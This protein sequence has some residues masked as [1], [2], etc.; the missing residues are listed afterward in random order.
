MSI[1]PLGEESGSK[2]KCFY[3]IYDTHMVV[4][5]PPEAIADVDRYIKEIRREVQITSQLAPL[6]CIVPMVSVI[7]KKVKKLPFED[8]LT[9]EQ[10]EKQYIRLVEENPEYQEYLKIGGCFAFFYGIDQ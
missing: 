4:K 2:S 3:V 9:Q 10:L 6:A 8:S 7:L 1:A 5:I